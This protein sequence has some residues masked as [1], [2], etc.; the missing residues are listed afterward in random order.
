MKGK[1]RPND[2][3]RVAP[4][5]RPATPLASQAEIAAFI[6]LAASLLFVFHYHLAVSLL[7][8]LLA[9]TLL[10]RTFRLMHGER[11]SRGLAKLLAAAGVGL[12]AAI[13]LTGIIFLIVGFARGRV[14]ALPRLFDEVARIVA[15]IREQLEAWGI[16]SPGLESLVETERLQQAVA[17]WFREHAAQLTA[18]GGEAGKFLVH[19]LVGAAVGFLVFFQHPSPDPDRPL[20]V[21]MNERIRRFAAAFEAVVLAQVEIS[22]VNSILTGIYLFVALP[23]FDRALPFSGTLLA[24]TFAAGLLPVVGNLISNSL[25]VAIS[26]GVSPWVALASLVFLIVVHK[27]EYFLNA[28]IVGGRVGATAW[29]ILLAMVVFEAAFGLFGVVLAPIVYA[30]VKSELRDHRLV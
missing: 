26:A 11:L 4:D 17:E 30:Y 22:A 2:E 14:G 13:A 5:A 7:A 21:A 25:I 10:N 3:A 15:Q 8:G 19:A 12:V 27:L 28:R 1:R 6:L 9:Y 24:V 16:S 23:L 20:A 18:A 29:E